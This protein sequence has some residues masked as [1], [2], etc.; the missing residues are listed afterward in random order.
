VLVV[1]GSLQKP[2]AFVVNLAAILS[3]RE[4][5]FVLQPKD[6]VYVAQKPWLRAEELL[7]IALNAYVQSFTTT[8]V[9]QN[10]RTLTT[11]PLLPLR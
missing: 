5:D 3:G 10:I 9:G 8:W 4:K 6:I 1:R 11:H 7:Q 2:Q